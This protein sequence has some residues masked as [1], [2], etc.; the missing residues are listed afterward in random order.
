MSVCRSV[1][2]RVCAGV[3]VSVQE[4]E[5]VCSRVRGCVQERECV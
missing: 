4:C 1:S 2:E 3:C 5:R